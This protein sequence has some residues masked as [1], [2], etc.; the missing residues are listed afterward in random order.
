MIAGEWVC[1]GRCLLLTFSDQLDA[2]RTVS[3]P[4][5]PYVRGARGPS[6]LPSGSRRLEVEREVDQEAGPEPDGAP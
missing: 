2:S 4:G 5:T 1:D 3:R 6:E